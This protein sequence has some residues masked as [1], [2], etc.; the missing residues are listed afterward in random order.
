MFPFLYYK[1]HITSDNYHSDYLPHNPTELYDPGAK[2]V[3]RYFYHK[4]H[5]YYFA[6]VL[7]LLCKLFL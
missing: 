5:T 6:F 7:K 3:M 1:S 4:L 2:F